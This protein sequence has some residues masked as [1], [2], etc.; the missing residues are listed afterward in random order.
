ME[1]IR[2]NKTILILSFIFILTDLVVISF[3]VIFIHNFIAINYFHYYFKN[4]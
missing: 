4:L 1:K 3:I 2:A